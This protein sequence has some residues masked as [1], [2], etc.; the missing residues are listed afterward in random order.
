[1][2]A[3]ALVL[4]VAAAAAEGAARPSALPLAVASAALGAGS[5]ALEAVLAPALAGAAPAL[6]GWHW[7]LEA[8]PVAEEGAR[9]IAAGADG[10]WALGDARGVVLGAAPLGAAGGVVRRWPVRG[11]VRDL[12]FAPDGALWVAGE[13]GLF[14]LAGGRLESRPAAPGDAAADVH[15]VAVAGGTV[16]VAT[17][18]GV[19]WSRDGRRFARVEGALAE[20]PATGI[21]L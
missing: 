7:T 17:T 11:G 6:P 12:A 19:F 5:P 18:A 1:A 21:A 8:I 13:A 10:R 2:A 3:A 16:A 15:R 9:A 14:R 4:L 20:E